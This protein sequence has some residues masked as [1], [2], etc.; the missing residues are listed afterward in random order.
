[1]QSTLRLRLAQAGLPEFTVQEGWDF[2]TRRF[3]VDTAAGLD[4]YW[5]FLELVCT[6]KCAPTASAGTPASSG[7]RG[8][9]SGTVQLAQRS[10]Q[11]ALQAARACCIQRCAPFWWWQAQ[12]DEPTHPWLAPCWL[13]R[14]SFPVPK[15]PVAGV[16]SPV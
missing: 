13:L 10:W 4:Q 16:V 5:A 14:S 7:T 2:P 12:P 15:L 8:L 9:L 1:M 11:P 3:P 6:S